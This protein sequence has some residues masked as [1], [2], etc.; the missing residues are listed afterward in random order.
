MIDCFVA[1]SAKTLRVLDCFVA[2]SART[3]ALLDGLRA[4][5]LGVLLVVVSRFTH[6]TSY[7]PTFRALYLVERGKTAVLQQRIRFLQEC[8]R[9]GFRYLDQPLHRFLFL[10]AQ[11]Q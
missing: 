11:Q 1:E 7:G 2:E 9:G 10:A 4:I 5:E 6:P 3:P 8:W